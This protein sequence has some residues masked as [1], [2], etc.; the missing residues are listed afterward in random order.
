MLQLG[1][2]MQHLQPAMADAL[3]WPMIRV[4]IGDIRTVGLR[5]LPYGPNAQIARDRHIPLLDI[6]TMDH[7]RAGRSRIHPDIRRFSE[8]GV[9]FV[10]ADAL[11]V[12]AVVLATGYRPGLDQFLVPWREVCDDKGIPEVS[13]GHTALPGLF[14]CGQFVSP[15]GMLREIKLEAARI[16]HVAGR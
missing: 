7:I 10:D 2:V 3:A 15:A 5:R 8:D 9:V 1:V 4:T 16:A 11:K 6:G 12:D 14:F 13:G